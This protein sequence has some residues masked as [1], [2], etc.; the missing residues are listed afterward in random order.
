MTSGRFDPRILDNDPIRRRLLLNLLVAALASLDPEEAVRDA[1]RREGNQLRLSGTNVD[2]GAIRRIIV[3]A[4]GKAA[5]AMASAV[6]QILWD[7]DLQGV[8]V[9]PDAGADL[10]RLEVV[11]GN[12]PV[13]GAESLAA[14]R[15]LLDLASSA[16]TDDLAIFLISGGGSA[17]AEVLP[18][19]LELDD[20]AHL[21]QLLLASGAAIEEINTVRKHL[22]EIKGGR[23]GVAA[24]RA[25]QLTL[26]ASD[27]VG[28]PPAVIASGPTVSDPGSFAQAL[29]VL[30]RYGVSDRAPPAVMAHLRAGTRSDGLSRIVTR[31]TTAVVLNGKRAAETIRRSAAETGLEARVVTT[32]LTGEARTV[33]LELVAAGRALE[34]PGLAV[35]AGETTVT[36]AGSGVGG[37]NQELA[38]AAALELQSEPQLVLASF[39]TDGVDGPTDAAGAIVDHQTVARSRAS[40]LDVERE[41]DRNNAHPTLAAS[42]DLLRCG[43]TGTNVGDLVMVYR[44]Q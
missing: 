1:L 39:A 21:N 23:L 26:I 36:L 37:R 29:A 40:G 4:L 16:T 38:L 10:E 20:L 31:Q 28:D 6:D 3:L 5:V 44:S 41:L 18:A 9:S 22:S 24:S 43:P 13:P 7:R 32:T 11:A 27:V 25:Q 19:G 15:R 17:L 35:Y 30:D 2:L 8:V 12:H 14:G 42:G 34:R 33:G